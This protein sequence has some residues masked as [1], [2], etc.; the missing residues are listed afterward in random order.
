LSRDFSIARSYRLPFLFDAF[1]G[2]LQLAVVFFISRTFEGVTSASLGGA[3]NY[4]A[5]AAVGIVISLV[6]EAATEGLAQRIREEQLSGSLEA[7]LSQ[8]LGTIPL[9]AGFTAFPFAFAVAR[10][11]V[12]LFI[13]GI[14]MD[15]DLSRTSWIG[16]M[17]MFLASAAALAA[18]GVLAGAVVMV[19]KRGEVLATAL[20]FAMTVVS[21]AAFPIHV[22]P[23]WLQAIGHV[24]PLRFAFDGLRNA[25]FGGDWAPD[26]LVLAAFTAAGLPTAIWLFSHALA[27]VRRAGSLG[28]Y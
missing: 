28:Q 15:L 18:L 26:V 3:P 22:L 1:F 21:G 20:L 16:L 25:L 23:G 11:A 9:C 8:P 13:A 2:V 27:E 4:F 12:Y 5:F 17:V 14:W 10:A 6:V 7:L 19:L 24:M